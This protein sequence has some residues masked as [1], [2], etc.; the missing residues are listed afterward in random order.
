MYPQGILN[1]KWTHFEI[2]IFTNALKR[3]NEN[4]N[5][6]G[7]EENFKKRSPN[8]AREIKNFAQD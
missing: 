7:T 6:R 1:T 2:G 5:W 3:Q 8:E 4:F